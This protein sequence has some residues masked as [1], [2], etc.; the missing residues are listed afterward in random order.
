MAAWLAIGLGGFGSLPPAGRAAV[1]SADAWWLALSG[2]FAV[3]GWGVPPAT[4]PYRLGQVLN[5]PAVRAG[6][7]TRLEGDAGYR[8]VLTGPAR[9]DAS[10]PLVP[11]VWEPALPDGTRLILQADDEDMARDWWESSRTVGLACGEFHTLLLKRDGTVRAH[12]WNG[13]GQTTVPSDLREVVAVA[14]GMDHSI[15]I[16]AD[17][18]AVAWGRSD[19]GQTAIP[20]RL[21]H[22]FIAAAGGLAHSL[23]LRGDGTVEILNPAFLPEPAA[24]V[25]LTGIVAVA[26]GV[27][28]SLAL[29]ATG[30]VLAWGPAPPEITRVPDAA[31]PAVAIAAGGHFSLA[32][33]PDGS[34]IAWGDGR[35][36][37]TGVPESA[38]RIVGIAAGSYHAVA[39]RADG[40][41]VTWGDDS[42]GQA[43]V[44][45]STGHV[46]AAAAGGFHTQILVREQ[47]PLGHPRLHDTGVD[48]AIHLPAG[49]AWEIDFSDNWRHWELAGRG[50]ARF[51]A[52]TA[53]LP[54]VN[55]SHGAYRLRAV[56]YPGASTIF[57]PA[58]L[59]P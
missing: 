54:I 55:P 50:V 52:W 17:G 58:S 35:Y 46:A 28:H 11:F 47:P 12:G 18:R 31:M 23:L 33:R 26:A 20:E 39:W 1:P 51:G 49:Q 59:N 2:P 9:P 10:L 48:V 13:A 14:A 16:R 25:R 53:R 24:E 32:L 40:T 30:R 57:K 56:P 7:L 44:P 34:V 43:A 27:A 42:Q 19:A 41:L 45:E 5:P 38:T 22:G 21:N 6:E 36:G 4:S 3:R 15:A 29:T 37:Q 8:L